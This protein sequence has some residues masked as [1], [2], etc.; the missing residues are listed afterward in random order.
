MYYSSAMSKALFGKAIVKPTAKGIVKSQGDFSNY[1]AS[2]WMKYWKSK[3]K[4]KN[5]KYVAVKYKDTDILKKLVSDFKSDEIKLMMD[6]L[7]DSGD[8]FTIRGETLH[9]SSYGLYLLSS[10][11]ISSIYNKAIWWR[12]NITNAPKRGWESKEETGGV[13]IEF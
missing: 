10:A 7:W 13:T 11:F 12:D 3:A 5:I 9:Y 1:N 8:T 6:Y 4:E 2:E